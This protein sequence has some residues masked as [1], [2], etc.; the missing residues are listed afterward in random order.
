MPKK[1]L[2]Q[3]L[4]KSNMRFTFE[5]A[6]QEQASVEQ[7]E[8]STFQQLQAVSK[9]FNALTYAN[10]DYYLEHGVEPFGFGY[11]LLIRRDTQDAKKVIKAPILIWKL[12]ILRSANQAYKWT[13]RRDEDHP[14]MINPVLLSHIEQDANISIQNIA[15]DYL[16]DMLIDEGEL[17]SICERILKQLGSDEEVPQH[18]SISPCPGNHTIKHVDIAK[19]SI[20]WS[21]VFGLFRTQK[22]PIIKDVEALIGRSKRST[23][24]EFYFPPEETKAK[25]LPLSPIEQQAAQAGFQSTVFASISTDPSQQAIIEHLGQHPKQII[26]GPP[27]T[28]KSRSLTALITNALE[29]GAKCLVVCEKR[30]AL[31]VI[32]QNLQELGLDAL[33]VII[34]DLSKDRKKVVNVV[35]DQLD[36]LDQEGH[37]PEKEYKDLIK[38]A[39]Q[40]RRS[41]NE[42]HHFLRRRILG[43]Y[44]WTDVVG[45]YLQSA[46]IHDK[47]LLDDLLNPVALECEFEEYTGIKDAIERAKPLFEKIGSQLDHP[48][49]LIDHG[50]YQHEKPGEMRTQVSKLIGEALNENKSLL[51]QMQALHSEYKAAFEAHERDYFAKVATDIDELSKDIKAALEEYGE[52]FDKPEAFFTK[53][54]SL[55]SAKHKRIKQLQ[56]QV[57]DQHAA[58]NFYLSEY[59]YITHE[60]TTTSEGNPFTFSSLSL[61][62]QQLDDKLRRWWMERE[63][64]AKQ[65]ADQLHPQRIHPQLIFSTSIQQ[66]LNQALSSYQKHFQKVNQARL[67]NYHLVSNE[68]SLK[69]QLI[70]LQLLDDNLTGVQAAFDD[71][72]AFY[73]WKHFYLQL[74][75]AQQSVLNALC[76][77]NPENWEAAFE[78]WY[79]NW[80]LLRNESDHTPT[81]DTNITRL[82]ET[83][84]RLRQLQR[85]RILKSWTDKQKKCISAFQKR[86]EGYTVKRLYNKR[87]SKGQ[88]RNSL[89]K[90][91]QAD[92]DLFTS[93]FPV[94]LVDPVVCSS[95]LPLT[96]GLFDLVIFDEASQSRL[97]DT[98]CALYRGK[99]KVVSGDI[100]QMPPSDYFGGANLL[101][102]DDWS[103]DDEKD[104]KEGGEDEDLI[105]SLNDDLDLAEKASLLEYA[106]DMDYHRSYLDFHYRSHHPYLIDFSNAAFYGSRLVPMPAKEKKTEQPPII[107][108]AVDG[109]YHQSI[110]K[111]EAEEVIRILLEEIQAN[112]TEGEALTYPSVG[113][114]T[115]NLY[116]RN[117]ILD[118]IQAY[119][120]ASPDAAAKITALEAAG[121]FVKNLENVQGD[122]R[123]II[124]I[125][126]TFGKRLDGRFLQ[127]FGPLNRT[128]GYKLLNVIVTR[129]KKGIY[130][131]TSIPEAYYTN[132]A[133]ELRTKGNTG[134]GCLYA[135]LSYTRAVSE[136]NEDLRRSIL[137]LLA[138]QSPSTAAH[139]QNSSS[140]TQANPFRS[141]YTQKLKERYG[142][143]R[144]LTDHYS[145]G[146]HLPIVLLAEEEGKAST[147]IDIDGAE[148]YQQE[149]PYA[150]DLYRDQ[151]LPRLG[152]RLVR[153]YSAN[154]WLEGL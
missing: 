126:T 112:N 124:I 67:L 84:D 142:T 135:Y 47:A 150:Y 137:D 4:N 12:Q 111:E 27:G 13:V 15:Q 145:G 17:V 153:I 133:D 138:Q 8:E 115:F 70:S 88:K 120:L 52:A 57:I 91:V 75:K 69:G 38:K 140:N 68:N 55:F 108:K 64:R 114:A 129:A 127:N 50:R 59:P 58:L 41:L 105:E 99:F 80:T 128:K 46:E 35:R 89:R 29:N 110:N 113:I 96:E 147:V 72:R 104:K 95:L 139:S 97:E 19:P 149:V 60:L 101:L 118:R 103:E 94:L 82:K 83:L 48:L 131:C 7:M 122:E 22:Q 65:A 36:D 109:M 87:G 74:D 31:E 9:R 25:A 18:F 3:L 49:D 56:Q 151:L 71:F 51:L 98:F 93:F 26:Q 144:V 16:D 63:A 30:T 43:S 125:S 86:G 2:E 76:I 81:N 5:L 134:K 42:N 136:G 116:Q 53:A 6:Q 37:Y 148:A 54:L 34:E 154:A 106:E 33:S 10:R 130:V 39:E 24:L 32:Q 132:Y 102:I 92:F 21:G 77:K 62:L 121:L 28:G 143:A 40:L 23:S 85:Q 45:L 141:W 66:D 1:F 61:N 14:V 79:F 107:F 117:H 73:Q 152:Y 11:P 90:I 146:I 78:S 44:N 20:R 123:D 100:H 119:R